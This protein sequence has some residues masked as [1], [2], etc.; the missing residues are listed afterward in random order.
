MKCFDNYLV[1]VFGE[2]LRDSDCKKG[3][4]EGWVK[5][6]I[7]LNCLLLTFGKISQTYCRIDW[8]IPNYSGV[9]GR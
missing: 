4:M 1:S 3:E 5:G 9:I 7:F 2:K 6:D 8:M